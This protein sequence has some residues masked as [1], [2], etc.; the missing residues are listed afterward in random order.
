MELGSVDEFRNDVG[1]NILPTRT[2]SHRSCCSGDGPV[3]RR[4][5]LVLGI[6]RSRVAGQ[7]GQGLWSGVDSSAKSPYNGHAAE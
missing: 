7:T 4:C 5:S 6:W 1:V 3:P 2:N